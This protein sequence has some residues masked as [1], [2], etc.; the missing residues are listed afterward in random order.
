M[1]S[2]DFKEVK[3]IDFGMSR[4]NNPDGGKTTNGE[5]AVRWSAPEL[6]SSNGDGTV[7]SAETVTIS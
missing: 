7:F 2:K 1:V 6:F 5:V 3:I 4:K